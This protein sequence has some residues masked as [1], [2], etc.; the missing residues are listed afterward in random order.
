MRLKLKMYI[1]TFG[2][3]D[4]FDNSDYPSDSQ[5]FDKTNKKVIGKFQ[6]EAA[7]I[8]PTEFI[9]LRIKMYSYTKKKCQKRLNSQRYKKICDQ[10]RAQ[11][12]RL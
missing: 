12:S 11:T 4:R 8:P 6:D 1:V 2:L 5:Y 7:S 10:K 3:T 9:G